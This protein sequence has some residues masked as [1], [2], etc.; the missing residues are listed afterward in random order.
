[1]A[2]VSQCAYRAGLGNGLRMNS[3]SRQRDFIRKKEIDQWSAACS[4]ALNVT[5]P[6]LREGREGRS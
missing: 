5:A 3:F 2:Y 4:T 1:M 6:S